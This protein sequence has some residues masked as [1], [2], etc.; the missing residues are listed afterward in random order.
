MLTDTLTEY[1][2]QDE[3]LPNKLLTNFLET[4][5]HQLF[6]AQVEQTPDAVAVVFAGKQLTYRELNSR[7][8]QL[9]HYLQ[10]LGVEP[11]VLVGICVERSLEMVIGLLGIL[12]A[13]GAYVPLDPGYPKERLTFML[14]DS[15]TPVLLTTQQLVESLPEHA[16]RV[17]CLDQDWEIITQHSEENPLNRVAPD[18]LAYVMYTSGSTGRPKGVCVVHRGVVRLVNGTNYASF[19]ADEVFLQLSPISFDASTFEIW[20]SLL[21]GAQLVVMPPQTP[22]LQELGQALQQ[23]QVTTLWLTAGLFHLMVD[24]RLEDLKGLRQ[25]LAGGDVLSVPHV[26]RVLQELPDCQLINGYGP[27]ENT[28]FSCCYSITD[29]DQLRDSVPIGFP[30]SHTYCLLLDTNLDPTPIGVPGELYIG[31]AGLARGYLNQPELTTEKFILS[32]FSNHLGERLYK[33]GDL[34]RYLPDGR[35]EFLGRIDQQVKIRGFRIELG[36][37]EA[38]LSQHPGVRDAVVIAREDQPSKKR[39]VAYVVPNENAPSLSELRQFLKEN[40]PDY[41]VPSAFV[42]LETLPLNPNGKV[43]RRALPAPDR[44][45]PELETPFVA[46]RTSLEEELAEIWAWAM[47]VEQVGIYDNFF[48]LGGDSLLAAQLIIRLQE[49]FEIELPARYLFESPTVAQLAQTLEKL[50]SSAAVLTTKTADLTAEAVLDAEI[51]PQGT[52]EDDISEPHHIFLT[53]ATGFLGAFLLHELLQ[54]TQAQ[55]YCLVRSPNERE[56][57]KR[58]QKTLEKYSLWNPQL[59]ARII[60]VIGNLAQPYLGLSEEEFQKLADQIDTIYHSG[61]KVNYVGPY[62]WHKVANVIGTQEVL[63]LSCRGRLKPVHYI[64]S[65]ALWGTIGYFTDCK[66]IGE[67][68]NID[69]S[70]PYLYADMGYAQSKWVAEKLVWIAKSRGVPVSIFRPGFIMGHSRTGIGNTDDFVSR[71]IKGCIQLGCFPNLLDQRKE[72]IPVDFASQAIVH[73]SR[74]KASIGKAFHLVPIRSQSIDLVDFFE[75]ICS[76]GYPL[77][78]LTYSKWKEEL[79]SQTRHSQENALFPLLPMLTEQVYENLTVWELYEKMPSFDCRNT[80]DGL[81]GTSIVC[82]PMDAQLLDIYLSYF[83]RSGFLGR[84]PLLGNRIPKSHCC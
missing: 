21:N 29:S 2:P 50:Q 57:R 48:E 83:M 24:E 60:P 73:L 6:E 46:P 23:Y 53:G 20:G 27:T 58:L 45:R 42:V 49:A 32:P 35:I 37:I 18:N 64:S 17:V 67:E 30:I 76:A 26:K 72:M 44:S 9:A 38:V 31:G 36:E 74:Q 3:N 22:S 41:M 70:E 82:P 13:G 81:V 25:L 56:G 75:L 14:E 19:S 65:I 11:E 43:D 47:G 40:L 7:A 71:M 63:R 80:L 5:I 66:F 1:L 62:S 61:A 78:K 34:A 52:A 16:A 51:F 33:T 79:I 68:T 4:S 55:I 10:S 54:Q 8:N 12:K 39:L 28:T 77:K 59:A 69:I 15:L 84:Q